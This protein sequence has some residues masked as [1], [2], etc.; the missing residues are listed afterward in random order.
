MLVISR[1]ERTCPQHT[2]ACLTHAD[3]LVLLA[4]ALAAASFCCYRIITEPVPSPAFFVFVLQ[5]VFCMLACPTLSIALRLAP[6]AF[7]ARYERSSA[8]GWLLKAIVG[9]VLTQTLVVFWHSL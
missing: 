8:A 9:A 4:V 2:T 1:A 6:S 5:A 3:V 7:L